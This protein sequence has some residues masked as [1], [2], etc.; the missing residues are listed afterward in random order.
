MRSVVILFLIFCGFFANAQNTEEKLAAQFYENGEYEKASVLYKKLFRKNPGSIYVYEN[1]LNCLVSLEKKKE[2]YNIIEKQIKRNASAYNYKVDLG[3]VMLQFG[4]NRKAEEYFGQLIKQTINER[5]LVAV[6]SQAF[7]KRQMLEKAIE[8]Y[9]DG[10]KKHG[11]L[12]YYSQLL[13]LYRLT[14]NFT[15]LTDLSLEVLLIDETRL[16]SVVRL[17]DKV[18]EKEEAVSYLQTQTL[19]YLQRHPNNQV[20]NELLLEI[21]LQQKKYPSALRQV[22]AMDKRSKNEGYRLLA[23]ADLCIKHQEYKT[24]IKSYE[25]V[26]SLGET[27]SFYLDAETG[28]INTLYLEISS[29]FNKQTVDVKPL[30]Q[31][32]NDFLDRNGK[33]HIT[34]SSLYRLAELHIFYTK[35]ILQGIDLLNELI[36][37]P[38]QKSSEIASAKLLLGDAYLI[39][40]NIWDAKLMY[41]QVD[42]EFKEDPLGQEAK[43]KNAKLSYYTGDFEWAKGQLDILKT[44]TTQLISNNAIELSLLIQDNVGLDS[45][46]DAMI[47]YAN[48]EFL[49]YQNKLDKSS[50]IL[51]MLPF[52]YPKHTLNDEI[53]YLKAQLQ[54]KKGNYLAASELYKKVYINYSNDILADNALFRSARINLYVLDKPDEAKDQFEQL[55][56]NYNNSLYAVDARKIY[57]GLKEGKSK[58]ELFFEG[59]IN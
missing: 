26:M 40:N 5:N 11:I 47:E 30:V 24:A 56:L 6:L 41:G 52:K 3:Y 14:N 49:L 18:F 23:L 19:I 12:N 58:E 29:S 20:F 27:R 8:T 43:F 4:E 54:E 9:E 25:Y 16:R 21:Y 45:T 55:V 48:A 35:D 13:S 53:Y 38:R 15:D 10:S 50:D 36:K 37:I 17:I 2:A 7:M 46:E 28:L 33:T 1:Y 59:I 42:K 22:I 31:R 57:Y 34:A 39:T 51:N 32:I 44:A